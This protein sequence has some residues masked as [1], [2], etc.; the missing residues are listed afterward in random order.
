[1]KKKLFILVFII[2][3]LAI[4]SC[5]EAYLP[6]AISTP[7]NFLVVE[8]F[9]NS[10]LDSTFFKLTRTKN[11]GDTTFEIP[12][13]FA[14]VTIESKSGRKQFLASQGN[15][16]YASGPLIINAGETYRLNILTSSGSLYESDYVPV[17][18][19]PPI[20]S[21]TW[22][23]D[24][25]VYVLVSTHDA[26]SNTRFYRWDFD[27]TWEYLTFYDSNIGFDYAN[28]SLYFLDSSK[29]LTRCWSSARSTDISIGASDNLSQNIISQFP[30]T[31]IPDGSNK[32]SY[33]YSIRVK[34][35]ALSRP[36]FEYWQLLKKNGKDLGSIF[37]TQPADITGNIK[38]IDN[39]AEPVIGFVSASTVTEKRFFIKNSELNTW[40]PRDYIKTT[41]T[42]IIIPL[43]SASFYLQQDT[44]YAPAY[45]ISGTPTPLAIA[46]KICV[47]CTRRGGNT[48]KP[49]FW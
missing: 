27:E 49:S 36:A 43:D 28:D 6:P 34:Q 18:Q 2:A 29:I 12:E 37:G 9:I 15:G 41:C 11:L 48:N 32:I 14:S 42:P 10:G 23:Q 45:F 33:R 24:I 17:L 21:L 4:S 1:M 38:C 35:Y 25:D 20:D 5:R 31:K 26:T 40:T 16:I 39:P 7:N 3:S 44:S 19:T 13:M 22:K 8:G 46:K 30:L 47:D